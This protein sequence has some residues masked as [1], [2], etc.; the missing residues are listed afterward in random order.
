[1]KENKYILDKYF[2]EFDEW[3]KLR[4]VSHKIQNI[5]SLGNEVC[6]KRMTTFKNKCRDE[7]DIDIANMLIKSTSDFYI[8]RAIKVIKEETLKGREKECI[9]IIEKIFKMK[10]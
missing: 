10:F 3:V 8:N 9:E 5:K 6:E 2:N 1:M 4:G 7:H